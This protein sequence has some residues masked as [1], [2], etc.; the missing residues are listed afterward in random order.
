MTAIGKQISNYLV[1][2]IGSII[3]LLV[4]GGVV[5]ALAARLLGIDLEPYIVA[6]ARLMSGGRLIDFEEAFQGPASQNLRV[7]HVERKDTDGDNFKEWVVFFQFDVVGEKNLRQPCPDN[8]PRVVAIYDNDRGKPSVLFPYVLRAPNRDYLSES[9]PTFE[10]RELVANYGVDTADLIPELIFK[11]SGPVSRLSIFKYQKNTEPWQPP[12][13]EVPRYRLIGDFSAA[14]HITLDEN[15]NVIVFDRVAA[16]RSQLAI[17]KVY[18]LHGPPG[19][20]T[21]MTEIGA[22]SL[23]PPTHSSIDFGVRPPMDIL[24]S[25]YPEKIVLAF[26]QSLDSGLGRGWTPQ[27]FLAPNCFA[28]LEYQNGNLAYFGFPGSGANIANMTIVQLDYFPEV[29]QIPVTGAVECPGDAY[30]QPQR[31][32]RVRISF[33]ATQNGQPVVSPPVTFDMALVQGQWKI[34]KRY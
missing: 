10:Q 26:Y 15:G 2:T 12:T 22:A 18:S 14:G 8:S 21:Y 27:D 24:N 23:A 33:E 19:N 29:E 3:A 7:C 17:K 9:K 32:G 28:A 13:D 31:M 5:I 6:S 4:V 25:N 16:D 30:L 20:E 1:G 11:G 34:Y